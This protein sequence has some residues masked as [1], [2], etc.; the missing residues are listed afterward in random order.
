MTVRE[1][2]RG[3]VLMQVLAGAITLK[4]AALVMGVSLRQA[5]RLKGA[6][7]QEGPA[8]LTHGNRGR[9]SS[10]RT[11]QATREA[12][13]AHY[14]ATYHECNVQHVS[15]LLDERER[16]SL[17][18]ETVRRILK[19]AGLI[20]PKHR[21]A[22]HRHRRERVAA[23][24]MLLQIDA[25]PFRWLGPG[26]PKWTLVGGIDD[27]TSDPVAAVFREQEDAAGYMELL[28][29]VVT[30]KGIPAA[31][32]RDRHMIFEVPKRLQPSLEEELAG[33]RFPT[34]V[35]RLL[36]ELGVQSIPAYSPQAKGRV[37]RSWRTQQDR[38]VAELRLAGVQTIEQANEFVPGYLE[39]YRARFA[40]PPRSPDSAYVPVGPETD[41]ERL[42]CFKYQRKVAPDNTIRFGAGAIQIPAGPDRLSYA[43]VTVE[44][45]ERLDGSIAVYYQARQLLVLSAPARSQPLRSRGRQFRPLQTSAQPTP[46]VPTDTPAPVSAFPRPIRIP[47]KPA[48]NHPW[49]RPHAHTEQAASS[50]RPLAV[51]PIP[52]DGQGLLR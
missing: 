4:E 25:S 47:W 51:P 23:E 50:D 3:R 40:V 22:T 34:Q 5:R 48:R 9:L 41:L 28:R 39:R 7:A 1:Q 52:P 19:E 18:V 36:A 16:I 43:R 27:A 6:M 11:D 24:G 38:L 8:G 14:R 42:F 13:E 26:G 10:R 44:V 20:V 12:V 2:R 31:V 29:A 45:H 33:E 32:Y 17:S 15:E 21:R 35:G 37:E 49:R 30:T 46:L